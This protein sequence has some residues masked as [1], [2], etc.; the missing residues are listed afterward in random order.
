MPPTAS[1][2]GDARTG[3]QYP[4]PM[5]DGDGDVVT[6]SLEPTGRFSTAGLSRW[7]HAAARSDELARAPLG[8]V[9]FDVPVVL[10]RDASGAAA[11]LVDRCPHRNVPLSVGRCV[12]GQIECGYHGWRFDGAGRCCAVPGLAERGDPDRGARRVAALPVVES[13]GMVWVAVGAGGPAT[14]EPPRLVGVGEPGYRTVGLTLDVPGPM[15]AAVENALDVPHTSFLHR[16]LFRGRAERVPVGVTVRHRGD[17]I[18]AV[19]EGEPVPP[20][21]I[22]RLLSPD[23]GVVEHTDRFVAPALAQVEYRLGSRHIALNACYTPVDDRSCR[24]VAIAAYRLPIPESVA[25][26]ALLPLAR[27]ILGQDNRMLRLQQQTVERFGGERFV[28]T[29]IDVL[30]PHITRLVRRLERGEATSGALP[31]DEQVTLLT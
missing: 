29:P 2:I 4:P 17:A 5:G 3:W 24:L 26:S 14:A 18:E 27:V 1:A 25:R 8:R 7:W 31:A 6:G 30:G 22:G 20:G 15:L 13:D 12:H 9:V 19:F 28:H 16:G 23:G 10:F 11:A 21:L